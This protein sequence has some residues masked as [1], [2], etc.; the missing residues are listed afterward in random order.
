MD[1]IRFEHSEGNL[2][3]ALEDLWKKISIFTSGTSTPPLRDFEE[4]MED[5]AP[6]EDSP[7]ARHSKDVANAAVASVAEDLGMPGVDLGVGTSERGRAL[8]QL[9]KTAREVGEVERW[10]GWTKERAQEELHRLTATLPSKLELPQDGEARMGVTGSIWVEQWYCADCRKDTELANEIIS[11]LA[12]E[13]RCSEEDDSV[14][15]DEKL[16]TLRSIVRQANSMGYPIYTDIEED[17]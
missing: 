15:A 16:L 12:Q 5:F 3:E 7:A 13:L 4:V 2:D 11:D 6:R 1:E 17:G 9:V 14:E 8:Q 10:P